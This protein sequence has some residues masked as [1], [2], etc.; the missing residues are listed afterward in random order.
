MVTLCQ[1]Y[2]TDKEDHVE[3]VVAVNSAYGD[4]LIINCGKVAEQLMKVNSEYVEE[5]TPY[6]HP[7]TLE[8][9]WLL[10]PKFKAQSTRR[11][12]YMQMFEP[13]NLDLIFDCMKRIVAEKI[14]KSKVN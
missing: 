1:D 6:M 2:F 3:P 5:S 4:H 7:E 14:K 13:E 12:Y 10:T 11:K 8:D 9:S